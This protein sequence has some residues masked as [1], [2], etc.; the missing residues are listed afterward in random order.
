MKEKK[1]GTE[2]RAAFLLRFTRGVR[3]HFAAGVAFSAL[4]ILFSF[5]PPQVIRFTIDSVIGDKPAALPAFVQALVAGI[6]GRDYLRGHLAVCA[7]AAVALALLSGVS[8]LLCRTGMAKFSDGTLRSLRNGLFDHIQ[9]LP[10]A[11]HMSCQTGDIIQRCTS[12]V[13]VLRVFLSGQLLELFRTAFLVIIAAC[14]MFPMDP[15]LTLVSLAFIP[16]VVGYSAVFYHAISKRFREADEAEGEL[17][18][19]VQENLTGV[20]VV[21]AFG[22]EAHEIES[23]DRKNRHFSDLWIRLGKV[24]GL[25]W[26][27]GEVATALQVMAVVVLG[28]AKAVR[29]ELTIG[30]FTVFVSYCSTMAWPIRNFGRVLS[31]LSKLGVSLERLKEIWDAEPEA[32]DPAGLTPPMDGDIVFDHVSFS[33]GGGAPLLRDISFTVPAGSTVGILGGTGSGKS[34]LTYLLTRL[35]D[36][37][38]GCGSITVGGVDLRSMKLSHVRKNVGL[39]LQE[40]FLFSRTIAENILSA[41]RSATREELDRAS[42]IAALHDTIENLPNGYDTVVGERGVTL[43]GGQK[44][45]V[46]IARMLIQKTPVKIFDDSLSAVDTETD[47]KIRAALHGSADG[48]T[49]ILISHRITTLMHADRIIVLDGGRVAEQGTHAELIAREGLYKRIYEI[50]GSLEAELKGGGAE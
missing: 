15:G 12:D 47:A 23:F 38:E 37:K 8:T 17:S 18:A 14:L 42:G 44:Q 27:I 11:W 25:Y 36:V 50:Q 6:G 48:S 4:G 35:Y 7:G 24:L 9:R 21:R 40:P 49:V 28:A 30:E 32:D 13:D 22:R 5:L 1:K 34:T 39:V 46:A 16:A 19:D 26:G 10:Y 2:S 45:R 20:R 41:R 33:Y 31:D 3:G 43:S 29:G